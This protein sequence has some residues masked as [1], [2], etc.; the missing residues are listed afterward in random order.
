MDQ[1]RLLRLQSP[2]VRLP[3]Q[4][5]YAGAGAAGEAG[6][7]GPADGLSPHRLLA[8]DGYLPRYAA[9]ERPL[10]ARRSSLGDLGGC[11]LEGAGALGGATAPGS[12]PS[13]RSLVKSGG[14]RDGSGNIWTGTGASVTALPHS[15][16]S[17]SAGAFWRDRPVFVTGATGLV[18]S[19]LTRRLVEAQADVVCLV[20]D[21][22]PQSELV[23]ANLI[24]RV[25]IVRGD[26][27]DQALLERALGEYEID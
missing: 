20:R 17:A 9:P 14:E 26:V 10:G 24:E 16:N 3:R 19:W 11:H 5:V 1:R 2:R 23:R 12:R 27:R 8:R 25:K 13:R 6:Q 7:R 4:R 22:V 15:P 18:G 21:W